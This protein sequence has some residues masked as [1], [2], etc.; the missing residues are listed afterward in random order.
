MLHPVPALA[1]SGTAWTTTAGKLRASVCFANT[2]CH[3]LLLSHAISGAQP[4]RG[5]A[6]TISVSVL[7]QQ[8]GVASV[9]AMRP[10]LGLLLRENEH[11]DAEHG[12]T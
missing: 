1:P 12:A 9:G 3:T 7:S 10:V 4:R 8:H 2:V 11:G 6:T 5:C